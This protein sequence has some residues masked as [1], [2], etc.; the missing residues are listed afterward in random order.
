MHRALGKIAFGRRRPIE[1]GDASSV[2]ERIDKGREI[3]LGALAKTVAL[4]GVKRFRERSRKHHLLNAK[5][6]I[7][8]FEFLGQEPGQPGSVAK[9]L[10]CP[11]A[12][13]LNDVIDPIK[14][15]IEAARAKTLAFQQ[16]AERCHKLSRVAGKR[17]RR[18]DRLG[19]GTVHMDEFWWEDWSFLRAGTDYAIF[20]IL[21]AVQSESTRIPVVLLVIASWFALAAHIIIVR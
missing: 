16:A 13:R 4:A 14:E 3:G 9:R 20:G 1:L 17:L 21:V 6:R 19:K 15:E 12:D 2:C 8:G 10:G 7:D 11:S 18:A 5:A